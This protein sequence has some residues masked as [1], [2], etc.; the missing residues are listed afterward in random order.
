[1]ISVD[2]KQGCSKFIIGV[3]KYNFFFLAFEIFAFYLKLFEIYD[4]KSNCNKTLTIE[5]GPLGGGRPKKFYHFFQK[6][7]YFL[8]Q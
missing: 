4:Y 8:T 6:S 3:F 5:I 7:I 2:F 1:M